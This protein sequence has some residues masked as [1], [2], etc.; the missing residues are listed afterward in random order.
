MKSWLVLL[1]IAYTGAAAA[2]QPGAGEPTGPAQHTPPAQP[3]AFLQTPRLPG[4]EE[5]TLKISAED[6]TVAYAR[7][8]KQAQQRFAKQLILVEGTVWAKSQKSEFL[9]HIVLCGHPRKTYDTDE[10][11]CWLICLLPKNLAETAAGFKTGDKVQIVGT[12]QGVIPSTGVR[13]LFSGHSVSR[14]K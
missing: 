1:A 6:L 5:P 7:D 4:L 2:T 10:S 12:C 14:K 9:T 13:V 8:E 3:L 11:C